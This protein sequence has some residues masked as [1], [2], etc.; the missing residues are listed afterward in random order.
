MGRMKELDIRIRQGGDDAIAAVGE[1]L[2]RWIPVSE[3]LPQE[4]EDVIVFTDEEN[5]K[6]VHVASIDEDG[7]WCPSHG[8]GWM[9]PTVTHWM[10]LPEP[11]EVT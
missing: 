9:F 5:E 8:D 11:P 1:M 10:P 2:P 3:R 7:V 4:D 6:G